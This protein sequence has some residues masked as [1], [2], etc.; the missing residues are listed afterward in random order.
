MF[1]QLKDEITAVH[2]VVKVLAAQIVNSTGF[3]SGVHVVTTGSHVGVIN[4]ST[5]RSLVV[6]G[7]M[8]RWQGVQCEEIITLRPCHAWGKHTKENICR[9]L[10]RVTCVLE[11]YK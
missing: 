11:Q 8:G 7:A 9:Y 10:R 3:S 2:G 6:I 4:A 1:A 5:L